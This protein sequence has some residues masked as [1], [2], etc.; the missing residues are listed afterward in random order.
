M[1]NNVTVDPSDIQA[2]VQKMLE[3]Y[4]SILDGIHISEVSGINL[5]P[6]LSSLPPEDQEDMKDANLVGYE[7]GELVVKDGVDGGLF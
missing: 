7:N 6:P 3:P 5:P 1:I 2:L 4:A